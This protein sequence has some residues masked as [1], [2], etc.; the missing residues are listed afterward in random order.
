M[1]THAY[2]LHVLVRVHVRVH[3]QGY[4]LDAMERRLRDD[5]LE[6][7]A[8]GGGT[9]GV[10]YQKAGGGNVEARLPAPRETSLPVREAFE[11][12]NHAGGA[13]AVTYVRVPITDE[14]APDEVGPNERS[15]QP[16]AMPPSCN[17]AYPAAM[18]IQP[19]TRQPA[20]SHAA[21]LQ[22]CQSC[23]HAHPACSQAANLQP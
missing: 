18:C 22:P 6:A 2:I 9:I 12:V 7:A 11:R 3:V 19:A 16:A 15:L 8:A 5:C 4:E 13:P 14:T 1:C 17:H 10:Y 21:I 20:C 23:S